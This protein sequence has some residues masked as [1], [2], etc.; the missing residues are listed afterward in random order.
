[1]S[2][3][4]GRERAHWFGHSSYTT[5]SK[6]RANSCPNIC[7]HWCEETSHTRT[8][9]WTGGG[10][11]GCCLPLAS[12]DA[13]KANIPPNMSTYVCILTLCAA[14]RR[15]WKWKYIY[16][17]NETGKKITYRNAMKCV[18]GGWR[19]YAI[20]VL[21]EPSALSC[22]RG[23]G[24]P[25]CDIRLRRTRK[26]LVEFLKRQLY[27]HLCSTFGSGLVFENCLQ[28]KAEM[29]SKTRVLIL[30]SQLNGRFI[31]Y[32]W[33]RADLWDFSRPDAPGWHRY[34]LSKV[35]AIVTWCRQFSSEMTFE[36]SIW[37]VMGRVATVKILWK[38]RYSIQVCKL[39][40]ALTFE[41]FYLRCREAGWPTLS[42]TVCWTRSA[43]D[44]SKVSSIAVL[45]IQLW[46]ELTFENFY[47]DEDGRLKHTQIGYV[48]VAKNLLQRKIAPHYLYYPP[49]PP[50]NYL[51]RGGGMVNF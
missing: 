6:S 4:I 51:R 49:P 11:Q 46:S 8:I 3:S 40:I 20:G 44:F 42:R 29:H 27:S 36:N 31:Q 37:D 32:I 22:C 24:I 7:A 28:C 45:C 39:P 43:W 1:M 9:Q 19:Q 48:I 26:K 38:A 34:Q 14:A 25:R 13:P 35:I 5:V 15:G 47:L 10:G 12:R 41:N 17:Y 33:H 21:R 50:I 18:P 23:S 2:P 30:K 16:G